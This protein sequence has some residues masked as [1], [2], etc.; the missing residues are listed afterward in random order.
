VRA[1]HYPELKERLGE[2]V[3]ATINITGTSLFHLLKVVRLKIGEM[4]VLLDGDGARAVGDIKSISKRD[5]SITLQKIE[6]VKVSTP[7]IDLALGLPKKPAQL[8]AIRAA[9]EVGINRIIPVTTQFAWPELADRSRIERVVESAMLQSNNPNIPE[10]LDPISFDQLIQDYFINYDSVIT[11]TLD[12]QLGV[13]RPD[14]NRKSEQILLFIGPE[15]GES[16][17]E[18]QQLADNSK[19]QLVNLNMPILR[20]E[21]AVSVVAGYLQG[22]IA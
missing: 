21:T 1:I 11:F 19:V 20:S 17:S 5:I 22:Q 14:L 8:D 18:K 4:V 3:G 7:R 12:H 2:P 15:G 16:P 9:V 10:I 13:K 6:M